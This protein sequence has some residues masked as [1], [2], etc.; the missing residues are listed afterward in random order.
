MGKNQ[1]CQSDNTPQGNLQIH[2]NLYQ[3]A[4]DIFKTITKIC[5][6]LYGNTKDPK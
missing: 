2:C 1:Y 5:V 4:N 6:N 3:V